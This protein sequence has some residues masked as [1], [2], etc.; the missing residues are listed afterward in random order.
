[1]QWKILISCHHSPI[2]FCDLDSSN[3]TIKISYWAP[4]NYK[5][6]L[7]VHLSVVCDSR[8]P[9][10]QGV[11][12]AAFRQTRSWANF[13][14]QH[15]H[16]LCKLAQNSETRSLLA[17]CFLHDGVSGRQEEKREGRGWGE[18]KREKARTQ[19]T[20]PFVNQSKQG[21]NLMLWLGALCFAD[22]LKMS[23]WWVLWEW[24]LLRSST[25][26][27]LQAAAARLGM[28]VHS[29]SSAAQAQA[30]ARRRG[31]H[32]SR[33]LPVLG[34]FGSAQAHWRTFLELL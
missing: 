22:G 20:R 31:Q 5:P 11:G 14:P 25:R 30:R 2:K 29:R 21:F 32:Y 17:W 12:Q 4:F 13:P 8:T 27:A 10:G 16:P 23:M 33:A 9:V 18:Q 34:A 26:W 6:R 15:R 3:C 28:S 19:K 24:C 1:M 7:I